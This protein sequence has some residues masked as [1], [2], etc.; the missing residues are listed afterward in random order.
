M[1]GW[2][3]FYYN[4]FC[5]NAVESIINRGLFLCLTL[6]LILYAVNFGSFISYLV[7]IFYVKKSKK[8]L[9]IQIFEKA[10]SIKKRDI[11]QTGS[12]RM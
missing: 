7:I 12:Y 11:K 6:E 5:P 10:A 4:K 1:S 3:Q 2:I 8:K 9:K